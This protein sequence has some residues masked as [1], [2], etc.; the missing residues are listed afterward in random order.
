M[1]LYDQISR[2]GSH[3]GKQISLKSSWFRIAKNDLSYY[4][5]SFVYLMYVSYLPAIT[6]V[7]GTKHESPD[8]YN[9]C[10][11]IPFADM[12][13]NPARPP[14]LGTSLEEI[15]EEE[16]QEPSS[17]SPLIENRE[18]TDSVDPE[19]TAQKTAA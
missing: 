11:T 18:I 5:K 10:S 15:N 14:S 16:E 1:C 13:M 7:N 3:C 2:L 9:D 17:V 8:A 19:L 4:F 6:R 12:S